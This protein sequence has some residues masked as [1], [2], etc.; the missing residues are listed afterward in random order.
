[1]KLFNGL[2]KTSVVL[3]FIYPYRNYRSCFFL[4]NFKSFRNQLS[5]KFSNHFFVYKRSPKG[6]KYGKQKVSF[7]RCIFFKYFFV[8]DLSIVHNNLENSGT[9]NK[10]CSFIK[11]LDIMYDIYSYNNEPSIFVSKIV[12]NKHFR[13][14]FV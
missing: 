4:K 11:H 8:N 5:I 13:L 3:F 9:F 1:M 6:F 14:K 2:K 12:V 7:F 10:F